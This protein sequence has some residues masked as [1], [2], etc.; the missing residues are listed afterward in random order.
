MFKHVFVFTYSVCF[1]DSRLRTSFADLEGP[2]PSC[3]KIFYLSL[4]SVLSLC[5]WHQ[6]TVTEYYYY[7]LRVSLFEG[8][9]EGVRE[10]ERESA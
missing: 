8:V 6:L 3:L 1:S 10:K 7:F 4:Y 5:L 9:S 2:S